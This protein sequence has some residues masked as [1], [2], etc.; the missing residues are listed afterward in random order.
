VW[1]GLYL[2]GVVC[3]GVGEICIAVDCSGSIN[4][5]QLGLFEAEVRSIL[6][7]QQP[8]LVLVLYFDTDVQ[9]VETYHASQHVKLAP[10]GGGGTDF[11]PCFRW[12]EE[13]GITPQTLAFLIDLWDTF[14]SDVPPYPVLWG[15]GRSL[16]GD[17]SDGGGVANRRPRPKRYLL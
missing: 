5:R 16:R 14:P 6:A 8:R 12:L 10:V 9:K 3:E 7:G 1:N 13:R 4:A 15:S 2:P 17:H 11:R